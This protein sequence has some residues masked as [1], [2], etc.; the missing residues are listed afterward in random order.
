[1]KRVVYDSEGHEEKKDEDKSEPIVDPNNPLNLP[2]VSTCDNSGIFE[3][4]YK[5]Q[6]KTDYT[7]CFES[8]I[9]SGNLRR[10]I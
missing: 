2:T 9:E 1:M 7:L 4:Y 10:A 5:P 8:K 3:D 6:S